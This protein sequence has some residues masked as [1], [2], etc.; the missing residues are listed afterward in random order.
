MKLSALVCKNVL[1][2]GFLVFV[3]GCGGA[4]SVQNEVTKDN[5]DNM[6]KLVTCYGT[7][8]NNNSRDGFRG[9]KDE[10]E[11]RAFLE[12]DSAQNFLA[13]VGADGVSIDDLL[14]SPRDGQPYTFRWEV[15]GSSRGSDEPVVFEKEGVDGKR[16]VG[17]TSH[18]FIEATDQEYDDWLAGNYE[19]PEKKAGR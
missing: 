1:F 15:T 5:D 12:S 18:K 19:P 13:Y 4:Y 7:F 10:A 14:T 8:Q 3:T 2:L 17:F 9:P 16:L 11:F 6:K